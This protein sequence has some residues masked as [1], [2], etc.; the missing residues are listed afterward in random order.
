MVGSPIPAEKTDKMTDDQWLL[1]IRKHTGSW[2]TRLG[3]GGEFKGGA[4]QLSSELERQTKEDPARF[5]RL[6]TRLPKDVHRAYLSAILRGLEAT[7]LAVSDE[8]RIAVCSK[9][10]DDAREDLDVARGIADVLGGL[11]GLVTDGAVEMLS[12]LA[13]QHP[14]LDSPTVRDEAEELSAHG[15][16]GIYTWGINTARGAAA[17]AVG[18]L[19]WRDA[20]NITKFERVIDTLL[21]EEHPGVVSCAG[22]VIAAVNYHN[23]ECGIR[24]LVRVRHTDGLVF[25][26]PHLFRLLL[27]QLSER[28]EAIRPLVET[29]IRSEAATCSDSRS[30]QLAA[31]AVLSRE[32]RGRSRD[33]GHAGECRPSAGDCASRLP[34]CGALRPPS[35][36]RATLDDPL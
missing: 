18:K 36:V 1:A 32:Q 30:A 34:Q 14:H 22:A 24:L 28:F 35:M 12:W 20:S 9:A 25:A 31:L 27:A 26:T 33:G 19:I 15:I 10:Y 2:L 8:L 5:G 29:M 7:E 6:A 3:E 23:P 17:K 4:R 16:R 11:V 13:T 21:R